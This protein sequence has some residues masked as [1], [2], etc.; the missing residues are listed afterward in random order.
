MTE[1]RGLTVRSFLL[2]LALLVG[3]NLLMRV[4][5]F[6]MGRYVTAGVPPVAAVGGLFLL[7]VVN[8]LLRGRLARFRLTRGELLVVYAGL[9][10]GLATTNTYGVRSI[11]PYF[12]VLRYFEQPTNQFAQL[13]EPLPAW[14][15]L[16]DPVAIQGL[17][18]GLPGKGVPWAAW[19]GVLLG[20]GSFLLVLCCGILALTSLI[21]RPWMEHDRLMFPVTQL[22]IALT[23]PGL[24]L[25]I[26]SFFWAG[27]LVAALIN[28]TNI[29]HAFVEA[30]PAIKPTINM[31]QDFQP[32]FQ[33]L[34]R[35]V[36][37]NRPEIYGFAYWVPSEIL[38]SGWLCYVL[39]RVYAVMGT[40][41]GLDQP[42]FPFTQ[43]QATGGYL[44]MA[45]LLGSALVPH[46][47]S[48]LRTARFGGDDQREPLPYRVAFP[49]V[50]GATLYCG[51]FLTTGGVPGW[52]AF[53]YLVMILI[54]TLVYLR[55]RAEAG[56]ALE[57]IYP[58]DY[59]R[60]ALIYA[61]GSDTIL[62]SGHGP[63]GLTAFYVAGFLARFHHAFWIGSWSLEA[64]RLAEVAEV[65]QRRM[66]AML[67]AM[68]GIGMVLATVNYLTYNYAN[69]LNYFEGKPGTADWR[70]NTVLSSFNE[71]NSYVL[72]PEG[73]D[74]TRLLYI[75]AGG[76]L[77]TVLA[78]GR[79][80]LTGFPL[81]PAGYVLATAYGDTSPMW[82]PFL[83][84][85]ILKGG[86][87]R[88]GGLRLYRR[89]LPFFV[90]FIL[91]HYLL[92][93][94]GW[95]ILSATATAEVAGRYYTIFG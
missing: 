66:T 28:A 83:L 14:F 86:L 36:I 82:F 91:S 24:R 17:Y 37:Y 90:G 78:I 81:H 59:P 42:G 26:N 65:R 10:L 44:A 6:V 64:F 35:M 43:E 5:E 93:G 57:F 70:T 84:I 88:Y 73:P 13:A 1:R 30:I 63:Q 55:L 41:A 15:A 52:L 71:L 87:L 40:M 74:R 72:K 89:I 47:K 76:V 25:W 69:G 21:R 92:A 11:F 50:I 94:L 54:F 4:C 16:R 12:S 38:V 9:C 53:G 20:W 75:L 19:R 18:E 67:V 80:S 3:S 68:F 62:I 34:R 85:W 56:L 29:G 2:A 61:F 23:Q 33:H 79:R 77:T 22:P 49:M 46:L 95:S 39:G 31:P 32:P 48:A 58:Y 45:L 27:V 8:A 60:K 7:L 51:W